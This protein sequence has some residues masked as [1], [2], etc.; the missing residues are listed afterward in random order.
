M[1][2]CQTVNCNV[3]DMSIYRIYYDV[4]LY[5]YLDSSRI[6]CCVFKQL[7]V[8]KSVQ[9]HVL[10]SQEWV[11]CKH[12]CFPT[13][14]VSTQN[15]LVSLRRHWELE[16]LKKASFALQMDAKYAIHFMEMLTVAQKQVHKKP[17]YGKYSWSVSLLGT[18]FSNFRFASKTNHIKYAWD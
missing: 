2:S 7:C 15:R 14:C 18:F 1:H 8:C 11:S 17:E 16:V 5:A 4:I 12:C 3:I 10:F 13:I 6:F 9:S